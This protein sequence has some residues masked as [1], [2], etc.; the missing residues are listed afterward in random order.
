MQ[1]ARRQEE[2]GSARVPVL[3]N[4]NSFGSPGYDEVKKALPPGKLFESRT[5]LKNALH[6]VMLTHTGHDAKVD[7]SRSGSKRAVYRCV[8]EARELAP[9]RELI[10]VLSGAGRG[11]V[12]SDD[13]PVDDDLSKR[14]GGRGC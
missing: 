8:S 2:G 10:E 6:E 14:V 9:L 12:Q 7:S 13:A 3:S 11:S 5:A 1:E 4:M